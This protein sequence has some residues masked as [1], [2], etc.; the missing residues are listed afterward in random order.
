MMF[1]LAIPII[2]LAGTASA[3]ASEPPDPLFRDARILE[4]SIS[5]PLTTLVR[6]RSRQDYLPGIFGYTDAGGEAVALDLK[7]R[8]R[9]NFRHKECDYPPVL[10]NFVKNQTR[11]TLF[12]KQNKLKLVI[13]CGK[14]ERYEQVVL[15]EYLAYRLLNAVTD[16]SFQVRLLRA[17]YVNE[18]KDPPYQQ[19]YAFL[20]EHKKRLAERLD[21]EELAIERASV[22]AIRPD[23]LNLTSVFAFLIGNTDFSPIA[24]PP[25]ANCCHNYVLFG[26]GSGSILAVPYDFDQ[27]G[28]VDAPYAR[29]DYRF[30]IRSVRQRLYRG[31]CANNDY[32]DSSLQKFRDARESLY[33]LVR[34]Q[35]GL[36]DKVRKDLLIYMDDF[37]EIINDPR[38]V[39]RRMRDKCI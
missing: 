26:D 20:I 24:G 16:W 31:R 29:P 19:R 39:D 14:H 7:I 6:E 30:R 21:L 4:A 33:M 3:E 38:K 11:N 35:E 13:Q 9:G 17:T 32:L 28:F 15:R 34:E 23:Q 36:T 12:D 22:G 18:E 37:F 1:C 5:G 2:L 25:G 27:S 10:L 8:T